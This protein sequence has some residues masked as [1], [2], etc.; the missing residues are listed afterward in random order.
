MKRFIVLLA[1]VALFVSA[2]VLSQEVVNPDKKILE[3]ELVILQERADKLQ[4]QMVLTKQAYAKK[5][6]QYKAM[7]AKQKAVKKAQPQTTQPDFQ[8]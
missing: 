3:L 8:E 2:P 7:M 4:A 1:I 5:V 6:A